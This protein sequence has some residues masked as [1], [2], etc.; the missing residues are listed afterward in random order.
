MSTKALLAEAARLYVR[1]AGRL[2]PLAILLWLPA[3]LLNAWMEL[4]F[5]FSRE[6]YFT[7]TLAQMLVGALFAPAALHMLQNEQAGLADALLFGCRKWSAV[8]AAQVIAGLRIC[9]GLLLLIV[10]GVIRGIRYALAEEVVSLEPARINTAR[11]LSRAEEL[12][13]GRGVIV[14]A[15]FMTSI[16]GTILIGTVLSMIV[17]GVLGVGVA[18]STLGGVLDSVVHVFT[19]TLGFAMYR[20]FAG[21]AP[22]EPAAESAGEL[23][24]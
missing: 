9:F 3:D 19:N 22:V 7:L 23:L 12:T 4:R 11:A 21:N 16:F 8:L 13:D 5:G 24:A 17:E 18:Q 14:F 15:S 6:T 10:P 2:V 1:N 20:A